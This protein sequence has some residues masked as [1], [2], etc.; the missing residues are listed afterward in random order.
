MI[1]E[2][3]MCDGPYCE[4]PP[5]SANRYPDNWLVIEL[6]RTRRD[7]GW[8]TGVYG[9]CSLGCLSGWSNGKPPPQPGGER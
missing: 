6:Q 9:F 8:L 1:Q 7:I 4:T 5:A 2:M 3:A